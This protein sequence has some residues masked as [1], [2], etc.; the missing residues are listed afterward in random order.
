MSLATHRAFIGLG[1]NL[2]N[3][4]QQVSAAMPWPLGDMPQTRL[5]VRLIRCTAVR[6]VG[7]ADQPD[8]VNAARIDRNRAGATGVAAGLAGAGTAVRPGAHL[9]QCAAYAG[10]GYFAVR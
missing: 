6:P 1:S 9:S 5:L 8:F 10:S 4:Q 2:E 7:Y 3:P